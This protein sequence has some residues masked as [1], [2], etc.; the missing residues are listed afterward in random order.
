MPA[1]MPQ[2]LRRLA[3]IVSRMD[4]YVEPEVLTVLEH[5][6]RFELWQDAQGADDGW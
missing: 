4:D 2:C 5:K 1:I 3:L 6:R